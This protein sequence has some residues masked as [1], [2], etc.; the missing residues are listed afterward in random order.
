VEYIERDS[1]EWLEI[2]VTSQW[3]EKFF[4]GAAL[5][6]WRNAKSE[7]ETQEECSFLNQALKAD[8]GA[9][10]L[11]VPCGNGRLSVPMAAA[12]FK[13][14]GLDYCKEFVEEARKAASKAKMDK[15]RVN[16]IQGDMQ[17]MSHGQK[18]DGAFCMGNSFGYFDREGTTQFLKSVSDHLNVG[19]RFVIDSAMVAECFLVNGGEREWI[20]VD[21][22]FMLIENQY[23][24]RNGLVKTNYTFIRNGKEERRQAVH[25]IF[26]IGELSFMMEQANFEILDLFSSTDCDPFVLGSERLLL[27]AE[28]H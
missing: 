24:C 26:T 13:I 19:A 4:A 21:D 9:H 5:E 3:Y 17:A 11:D 28:K 18:S 1:K 2:S 15:A 23:D 8:E 16:F 14:T 20:K 12:G 10:L 7:E 25:W 6:L 22:M 27:V